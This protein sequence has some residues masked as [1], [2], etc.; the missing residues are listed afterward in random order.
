MGLLA[1]VA[2]NL[3][4]IRD[5]RAGRTRI[6][7]VD[8]NVTGRCPLDCLMCECRS[9]DHHKDWTTEELRVLADD[10]AREGVQGV[11]VGGGEPF[12]RRDI[13]EVLIGFARAGLR[14]STI[15]SGSVPRAFDDARLAV[16][17][18]HVAEID[19]SL[20][21][22]VPEEH[23]AI[24]NSP[25][26]NRMARETLA[27]LARL[28]RTRR[29]LRA[30][31]TRLNFRRVDELVPLAAEHGFTSVGFQPVTDAPN[32][33]PLTAK[34]GKPELLLIPEEV[35]EL[36]RTLRRAVGRAREFG[37]ATNAGELLRWIGRYFRNRAAGR[38][39]YDG[40]VN[41]FYCLVACERISLGHDG[42]V[43]ICAILPTEDSV[44]RKSVHEVLN[45]P[46]PLRERI[47]SGKLT[48]ACGKCFCGLEGNVTFSGRVDPIRNFPQA[49][50]DVGDKVWKRIAGGSP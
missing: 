17:D 25:H 6:R 3:A 50:A 10:I 46:H 35:P 38:P 37:L 43:S 31:I 27:A 20:D 15:T 28:R 12:V 40:L 18:Q 22:V 30:V 23:N 39:S 42:R 26:A 49:A 45:E 47:R 36:E 13:S 24:R 7:V 8:L 44:K 11:F 32:Y 2:E 41:K 48:E 19:L 16:L 34:V 1:A 33:P 29:N 21:S 5:Y 9:L 4:T 14:V